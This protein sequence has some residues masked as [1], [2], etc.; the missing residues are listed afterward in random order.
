V[1]FICRLPLAAGSSLESSSIDQKTIA[2]E[3]STLQVP[4]RFGANPEWPTSLAT[5][6]CV[7]LGQLRC[8]CQ[9]LR[10]VVQPAWKL[11]QGLHARVPGLTACINVMPVCG[12]F[13]CG[14]LSATA[15]WSG[16]VDA[17]RIWATT[18]S[19]YKAMGDTGGSRRVARK[20]LLVL[21]PTAWVPVITSRKLSTDDQSC[22][23]NVPILAPSFLP[24]PSS[25]DDHETTDA[26]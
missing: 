23:L 13:C 18:A 6:D 4:G 14:Q 7:R 24:I 22:R 15:T 21:T 20:R 9:V 11:R 17:A 3:S 5:A 8:P 12:V 1:E 19:G 10:H 25:G 26:T 16:K 2:S